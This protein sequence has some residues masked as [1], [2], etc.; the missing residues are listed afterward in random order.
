MA[1]PWD[2]EVDGR[3]LRVAMVEGPSGELIELLQL[4]RRPQSTS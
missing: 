2:E 1:P 3:S 4:P